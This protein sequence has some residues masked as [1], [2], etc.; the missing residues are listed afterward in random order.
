M[1][2]LR[3]VVLE[4]DGSTRR[5]LMRM[6]EQHPR[7]QVVGMAVNSMMAQSHARLRNPDAIITCEDPELR[8]TVDKITSA[9]NAA[10]LILS[11]K[12]IPSIRQSGTDAHVYTVKIPTSGIP[13]QHDALLEE[14]YQLLNKN[15][16][17]TQRA[18]RTTA[19]STHKPAQATPTSQ[20]DQAILASRHPIIAIGS[21]TGGTEALSQVLKTLHMPQAAVVIVQHIPAAFGAGFANRLNRISPMEVVE[22]SNGCTLLQNHVYMGVGAEHFFIER[23]DAQLICRIRGDK[24]VSGHC[25][26]VDVLFDSVAQQVGSKA[27][28]ALLT[29]MGQDGAKGLKKMRDARARTLAQDEATSVVWGMPGTAVKLGAAEEQAPLSDVARRLMQLATNGLR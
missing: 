25:P 16:T 20:N 26:S 9:C 19:T 24:K 28:G 8:D 18:P 5:K 12:I 14:M 17:T 4:K 13:E 22:A 2:T 11:S 21:S 3:V 29:G 6:L 7:F 15:S 23:K 27:V 1:G 10:I